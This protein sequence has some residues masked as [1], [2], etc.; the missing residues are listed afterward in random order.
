MRFGLSAVF[1]RLFAADDLAEDTL[2]RAGAEVVHAADPFRLG[3]G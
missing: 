3:F 1:P 2:F